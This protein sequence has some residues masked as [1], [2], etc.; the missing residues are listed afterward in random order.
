MSEIRLVPKTHMNSESEWLTLQSQCKMFLASKLLPPTVQD[1]AKAVTIAWAGREL[2]LPPLTSLREINIIQ[3]KPCLSAQLMASLA[4]QKVPGAVI[5]FVTP[6]EK[7]L[8]ECEVEVSRPGGKKQRFKYTIEMAKTAGLLSKSP[9]KNHPD[10]M[11][12]ARVISSACRAVFPDALSGVYTPEELEGTAI[13]SSDD[14]TPDIKTVQELKPAADTTVSNV[15]ASG[16]IEGS[17][18]QAGVLSK[19]QIGRL[20]A[21]AKK[22]NWSE[23]KVDA[24]LDGIGLKS[25]TELNYAQYQHLCGLMEKVPMHKEQAESGHDS[26]GSF[27]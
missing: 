18:A 24:Q 27:Q 9:W 5:D 19:A 14:K 26:E 6:V 4:H 13:E 12:R 20:W 22:H 25:V 3:G 21:I 2:G 1:L 17:K 16:N 23:E 11:L 10:A 15:K 7:Q 8:S